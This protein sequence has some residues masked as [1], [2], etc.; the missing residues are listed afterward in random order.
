MED[1]GVARINE[2][3]QQLADAWRT[4]VNAPEILPYKKELIAEMQ[5]L[6]KNQEVT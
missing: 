6:L 3:I 1:D 5:E 2:S 4:E